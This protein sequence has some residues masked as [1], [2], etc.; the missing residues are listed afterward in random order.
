MIIYNE[1]TLI[2]SFDNNYYTIIV[3]DYNDSII[4]NDYTA[5]I[6]F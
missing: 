2:M 5:S 3:N 1:L 4:E 6:S